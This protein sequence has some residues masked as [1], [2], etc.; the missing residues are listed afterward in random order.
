MS[1]RF[2]NKFHRQNHHSDPTPGY[3]DSALDPIAS[4]EQP[5]KGEFYSQGDI[6]TTENLSAGK[7][8]YATNAFIH[9]TL[10]AKNL[11]IDNDLTV[12][13]NLAVLG[14]TTQLDTLVYATSALT[15]TNAG[16]GPAVSVNQ[17]GNNSVANFM[18]DGVTALFVDGRTTAPG[19]V[20]I[21]TNTP[22]M[23]L[24]VAG[25]TNFGDQI[26]AANLQAGESSSVVVRDAQGYLRVDNINL[27]VWDTN[28]PFISASDGP[29]TTTS[30]PVA[31]NAYGVKTGNIY[32]KAINNYIGINTNNPDE[33][34]HVVGNAKLTAE[35]QAANIGTGVDNSV[36][37]LDANGKLRTD[38]IN[39]QVWDTTAKFV[40]ASD[41]FLET[42]YLT[43]AE[44]SNGINQSQ[45]FDNGTSVGINTN[46][47]IATAKLHVEGTLHVNNDVSVPNIGTGVDNSVVILDANG[48]L[49]TDE[50]NPQVWDTTA[51]FVSASDGFLETNYLTKAENSN[52]INQSLVYDTGARVG[53]NTTAPTSLLTLGSPL[54][55]TSVGQT[56]ATNAGSLGA[57]IG[58]T[59]NLAN[60]GFT[61]NT[62]SV[63]LGALASRTG[64]VINSYSTTKIGLGFFVDNQSIPQLW[65]A[66]DGQVMISREIAPSDPKASL[67]VRGDVNIEIASQGIDAT[68]QGGTDFVT[69]NA[70]N[71]N[72][73][74]Q[75]IA[76]KE[77]N[78][79]VGAKFGVKNTN[80][81]GYDFI[82]A[83]R[84][85]TSPNTPLT[86]KVR[87][88]HDGN[89]GIGTPNPQAKLSVN[90][91]L[92]SNSTVE[93]PNIGTGVDN[94][95]VILDASGNL[96]TDE[97]NP[98]VWDTAA[99]FLTR[100]PEATITVNG[101][102]TY[103]VTQ[104]DH[105]RIIAVTNTVGNPTDIVLPIGLT[106]GT[107]ITVIRE[108]VANVR[109]T[110][111]LAPN[112]ATIRS[113][114]N[115]TFVN[116][117]FD[118]SVAGAYYRGN[119]IWYV[120]GDL[121]P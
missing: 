38:E 46:N 4:F 24:D 9:D 33:Q 97:I 101:Q 15:I 37:I 56:F 82:F 103:N 98:Q 81:G 40:S 29:L 102:A 67:D 88:R 93:F 50:I 117:A 39:P 80:N 54:Q 71:G 28:A 116:L 121:I 13:G 18:D 31:A 87:V 22:T 91:T 5:F 62:N 109:F 45:I 99:T 74:E 48:K 84:S 6:I 44:N 94:S 32:Q 115:N 90:G 70:T 64:D 110:T 49:R 113:A 105:L 14:T 35:I 58:N 112:N 65:F 55:G 20:G 61:A 69:L 119:N 59:L 34:L 75:A 12:K 42:N 76:F 85:N 1:N 68:W 118:N 106:D 107:F 78:T 7:N 89:V 43:K 51:K 10:S 47:P 26:R 111:N 63:S 17:T 23:P 30:F 36:V 60:V 52:G 25:N 11:F 92:S 95:V 66:P 16:T 73:S 21:G 120:F 3:P 77:A 108:G 53:I 96:K 72:F 104:A 114:P 27:R 19:Y 79:D 83:N 100:A 8:L 86:E 2:H 41:G 57:T